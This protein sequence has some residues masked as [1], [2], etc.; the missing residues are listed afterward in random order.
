MNEDE[1]YKILHKQLKNFIDQNGGLENMNVSELLGYFIE[2]T[3][4]ELAAHN[5]EIL[6]IS[7][8]MPRR[9]FQMPEEEMI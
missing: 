2:F 6:R 8:S 4:R 9:G 1:I 5:K 3:L 7:E